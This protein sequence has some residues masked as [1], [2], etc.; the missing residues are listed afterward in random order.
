MLP[1]TGLVTGPGLGIVSRVRVTIRFMGLFGM[2]F[3]EHL[4]MGVFFKDEFFGADFSKICK[5]ALISCHRA[6]NERSQLV[7][8]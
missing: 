4:F 2:L 7:I 8:K 3:F 6:L 5:M 1:E